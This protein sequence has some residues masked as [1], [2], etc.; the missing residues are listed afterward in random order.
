VPGKPERWSTSTTWEWWNEVNDWEWQPLGD[1]HQ[2][3]QGVCPRCRHPMSDIEGPLIVMGLDAERG[4]VDRKPVVIRCNCAF[5]HPDRPD[6]IKSGCGFAGMFNHP[7]WQGESVVGPIRG[8]SAL[9][10]REIQ[11]ATVRSEELPKLR[12][13]AKEWGQTLAALFG[14]F[15]IAGLIQGRDELAKIADNWV[16]AIVACLV[17]SFVAAGAAIATAAFAA[18]GW[19]RTV[20]DEELTAATIE[21]ARNAQSWLIASR[22]TGIVALFFLVAGI[23]ITWFGPDTREDVRYLVIHDDGVACGTLGR[24]AGG[25]ITVR[26]SQSPLAAVTSMTEV[27]DCP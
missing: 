18:Q 2:Q 6:H 9:I 24:T 4:A 22:V 27:D 15:G 10:D 8:E 26:P 19:P 14:L 3:K 11:A 17:V 12:E 16:F 5:D 21:A 1:E 23:A 13:A 25:A 7:G 20:S